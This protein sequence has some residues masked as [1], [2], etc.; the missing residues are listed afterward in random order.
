MNYL[1]R[2]GYIRKF[3]LTPGGSCYCASPRL[4]KALEFHE[5][6][7]Y[8]GLHGNP[9]P[10]WVPM[11]AADM[12]GA[13]ARISLA[14]LL[15]ETL[16]RLSTQNKAEKCGCYTYLQQAAFIVTVAAVGEKS[17]DCQL[18]LGA[19]WDDQAGCEEFESILRNDLKK[20][21]QVVRMIVA[22]IDVPH[23]RALAKAILSTACCEISEAKILLYVLAEEQYY[24]YTKM[25]PVTAAQV[26]ADSAT[27]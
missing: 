18:L 13:A 12:A 2:K 10:N 21:G 7:K 17:A 8:V 4:E 19:F 5:A 16:Q 9:T 25:E 14:R 11:N 15:S 27:E 1:L 24:S 22:G 20:V 23:A 26:G 6:K 3:T